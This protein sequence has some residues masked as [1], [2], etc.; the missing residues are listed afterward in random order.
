MVFHFRSPFKLNMRCHWSACNLCFSP[1]TCELHWGQ[2]VDFLS[3]RWVYS[4]NKH[5]KL[6]CAFISPCGLGNP[7]FRGLSFSL[8]SPHNR[9]NSSRTT[10]RSTQL[11]LN[12]IYRQTCLTGE[13]LL[14]IWRKTNLGVSNEHYHK[15]DINSQEFNS[16]GGHFHL[17][18]VNVATFDPRA[19]KV[20]IF[21]L[22]TV[23]RYHSPMIGRSKIWRHKSQG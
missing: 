4:P 19:N 10:G 23:E 8:H 13:F 11:Q 17:L 7:W 9:V 5:L 2:F 21:Y 18:P 16:W 20:H 15:W 22:F 3:F 12:F 1:C 14:E 6:Y